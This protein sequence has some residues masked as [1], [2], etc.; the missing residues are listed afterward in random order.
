MQITVHVR[1]EVAL[2]LHQNRQTTPEA[3][4]VVQTAKDLGISLE[5]MHPG[6]RDPRLA[7]TF[8]VEVPDA[9]MAERVTSRLQ[10]CQAIEAAYLKPPEALP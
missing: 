5:A 8:V 7:S 1:P 9:V 2:Q 6:V 3:Q 10:H 4:E